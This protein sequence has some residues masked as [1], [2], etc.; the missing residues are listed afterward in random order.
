MKNS[1]E[2]SIVFSAASELLSYPSQEL[3]DD[4]GVIGEQIGKVR[5]KS[6]RIPLR[7]ACE[8]ISGQTLEQLQL[9]YVNTF[10]FSKKCTLHLT[11]FT[12]GDTRDR[13][14]S[15]ARL[16]GI[17]KDNGLT[18]SAS[19]LPDFLPVLLEFAAISKTGSDILRELRTELEFLSDQLRKIS[20]PYWEAV[21]AVGKAVGPI[22]KQGLVKMAQIKTQG[23]PC[24]FVGLEPLDQMHIQKVSI[25]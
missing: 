12:H 10:D 21:S 24:E 9:N 1:T 14:S 8:W 18:L 11:Y 4:L 16:A 22:S 19:E 25:R 20:S 13:G 7:N 2:L 3:L 17:Y 23:T 15:L 5:K 6:L